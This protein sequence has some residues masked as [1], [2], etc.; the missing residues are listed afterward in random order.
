M[1]CVAVSI[2]P[3][4]VTDSLLSPRPLIPVKR[5]PKHPSASKALG[6]GNFLPFALQAP[7]EE[8]G[9]GEVKI[10]SLR[11]VSSCIFA[12]SSISCFA[13]LLLLL[14]IL[15]S[16]FVRS[17]VGCC[18]KLNRGRHT[19][20]HSHVCVCGDDVE[21]PDES[22]SP[23]RIAKARREKEGKADEAQ[24]DGICLKASR[25]PPTMQ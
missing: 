4:R 19:H 22:F 9:K 6:R 21:A 2:R 23:L 15:L 3:P 10:G 8:G 1:C 7:L 16:S 5:K 14:S 13:E 25:T 24:G 11:L 20:T 18:T 12:I 17:S